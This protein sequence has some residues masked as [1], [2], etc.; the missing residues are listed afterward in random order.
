MTPDDH[1]MRLVE[2]LLRD[3]S[4]DHWHNLRAERDDWTYKD[5]RNA[6]MGKYYLASL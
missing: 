1:M 3:D 4:F 2:T 6:V 5:F